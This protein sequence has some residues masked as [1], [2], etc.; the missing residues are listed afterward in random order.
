VFLRVVA[1]EIQNDGH[2]MWTVDQNIED[3]NYFLV[4]ADPNDYG[5]QSLHVTDTYM[6]L[7]HIARTHTNNYFRV[8]TKIT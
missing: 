5:K 4:L 6:T 1:P 7:F 2:Y 3:G 8:V